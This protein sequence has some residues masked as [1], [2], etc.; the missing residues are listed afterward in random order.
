MQCWPLSP[1]IIIGMNLNKLRKACCTRHVR[2]WLG[3]EALETPGIVL[4]A[5]LYIH[6]DSPYSSC[7]LANGCR[8]VM[9]MLILFCPQK[10]SYTY[11]SY[12]PCRTSSEG[13]C[14]CQIYIYWITSS[15]YH[16]DD[17]LGYIAHR[18][19]W[20]GQQWLDLVDK[21]GYGRCTDQPVK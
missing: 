9:A 3:V 21:S 13:R 19:A 4:I 5:C 2:S 18:P 6:T 8:C 15:P 11:Y 14:W 10:A 16:M 20:T 7:T 17:V 12:H 1:S